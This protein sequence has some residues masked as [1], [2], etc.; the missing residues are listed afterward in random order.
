MRDVSVVIIV[1]P[2]LGRV[3]IERSCEV[4]NKTVLS[5]FE[6]RRYNFVRL[7]MDF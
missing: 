2:S 1:V 7:E 6:R 3:N 5:W 4:N